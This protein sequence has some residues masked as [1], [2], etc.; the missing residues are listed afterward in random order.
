MTTLI[1]KLTLPGKIKNTNKW[2]KETGEFFDKTIKFLL[3][4]VEFPIL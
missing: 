3:K 2:H 4:E 1:I